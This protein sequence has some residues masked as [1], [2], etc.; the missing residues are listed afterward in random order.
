[1]QFLAIF[2]GKSDKSFGWSEKSFIVHA[3]GN[4][5]SL[6]WTRIAKVIFD[7]GYFGATSTKK[8]LSNLK[9][10]YV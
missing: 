4:S 9:N 3:P 2:F 10:G 6:T 8:L 5:L 7:F 1:M